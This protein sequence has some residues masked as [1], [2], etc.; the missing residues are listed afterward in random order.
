MVIVCPSCNHRNME[1]AKF[2]N[3]CGTKLISVEETTT[4]IVDDLQNENW[5][6][7]FDEE[8]PHQVIDLTDR[9]VSIALYLSG[10]DKL[11][12][13]EGKSDFIL[14][15]KIKDSTE[16]IDIDFEPYQGY[17]KGVS[18][19]HAKI[20]ISGTLVTITDMRSSNGTYVNFKRLMPAKSYTLAHGDILSLG[21]LILQYHNY[22]P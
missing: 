12:R 3:Q 21:S 6:D 9:K 18:R 19:V 17:A 1:D 13:L 8:L 22:L 16:I 7:K 20:T 14:G 5:L 11:F 4:N 10:M 15:R 2:C